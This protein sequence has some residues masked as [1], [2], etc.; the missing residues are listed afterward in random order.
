MVDPERD[1]RFAADLEVGQNRFPESVYRFPAK[2]QRE[3][4]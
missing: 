2:V 3:P 1:D 4:D